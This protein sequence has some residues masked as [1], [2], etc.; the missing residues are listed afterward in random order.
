MGELDKAR[1]CFNV[2]ESCA[3]EDFARECFTAYAHCT[4]A[5][6]EYDRGFAEYQSRLEEP[7]TWN[8]TQSLRGKT[9]LVK[10]EGGLGDRS[11]EHTSELQSH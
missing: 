2:A 4:L 5:L 3:S 9:L 1:D 11:E 7:D 6:G 8:G 10:A